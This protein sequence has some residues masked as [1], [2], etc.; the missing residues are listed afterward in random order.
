MSRTRKRG[1]PILAP[2]RRWVLWSRARLLVSVAMV[3]LTLFVAGRVINTVYGE[4]PRTPAAAAGTAPTAAPPS[5]PAPPSTSA[6]RPTTDPSTAR[7]APS[8]VATAWAWVWT[9]TTPADATWTARLQP[10]ATSALLS[11][12]GATTLTA[13]R[14]RT[15]DAPAGDPL[16]LLNSPTQA[17]ATVALQSGAHLTLTVTSGADGW[18]VGSVQAGTNPQ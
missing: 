14:P 16:T 11:G 7:T 13:T 17:T 9:D 10:L 5:T 15:S 2:I 6:P 18:R 4:P 1:N 3:L 8:T 12:I